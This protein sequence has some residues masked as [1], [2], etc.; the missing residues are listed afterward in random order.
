MVLCDVLQVALFVHKLTCL[1]VD[2]TAL[3][4]DLQRMHSELHRRM[5]AAIDPS[6]QPGTP[7]NASTADGAAKAEASVGAA[8]SVLLRHEGSHS[9][10]LAAFYFEQHNL[11]ASR[12]IVLLHA[13][14]AAAHCAGSCCKQ[15]ANAL[16]AHALPY[17][18]LQICSS[19][20]AGERQL[21]ALLLRMAAPALSAEAA[22]SSIGLCHCRTQ[23]LATLMGDVSCV[24]SWVAARTALDL[25]GSLR[26]HAVK[27]LAPQHESR[28]VLAVAASSGHAKPRRVVYLCAL[29]DGQKSVRTPIADIRLTLST[30]L[31]PSGRLIVSRAEDCFPHVDCQV[32]I[33]KRSTEAVHQFAMHAKKL[34]QLSLNLVTFPGFPRNS[35]MWTMQRRTYPAANSVRQIVFDCDKIMEDD[36]WQALDEKREG[37]PERLFCVCLATSPAHEKVMP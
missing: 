8:L 19:E 7:S 15:R 6:L 17:V 24:A 9:V 35:K 28:P 13:I 23:L 21:C 12:W 11:I 27:E 16:A 2:S 33:V 36:G 32:G 1:W 22:P 18:P 31:H 14:A 37:A 34:S 10:D 29:A 4:R 25:P 5:H 20:P 3:H 26:D 30:E